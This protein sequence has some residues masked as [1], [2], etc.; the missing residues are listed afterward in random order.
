MDIETMPHA[1]YF[2]G[3][4]DTVTKI[5]QV[6]YQT[7]EY[8]E[9]GMFTAKLMIDTPIEIFID[10]G[11]TPSI[12]PLHT[13]NKFP[14]LCTYPKTESNIP[15]HTG[16]GLITS[17]FWLEI[18]LKLQHQTI[19]IKALVCDSE[20]PYDLILGRISMAQLSAWQDYTTNKLYIQQISIPLTVRN[21]IRILPGKTGIVT[22]T[23]QPNK[24]S[25][26][27]RHTIIG[28]G[29]AYVKLLDQNLPL[30]PI[31]IELKNNHCCM[32]VHNTS[33][34]TVEF[35]HGQEMAYFDARSKGLVQ[36]NNSKHFPIDQYLHDRMTPATL[37]PS[38]LAYEKPI[39]PT[40]IPCI[41]TRTE[42]PIDVTNKSTPDDK[43]PR[44]DPDDPRRNM[45]DKEIL[46][47]KLNLKDSI[48][49]EKEKEEFLM[50]VEQFTDVFSLRDEIGTCP[51]IEVHLKL[52]DKTPFFVRPY[53]MREEQK[54]V[55]QKEM[56]RLEH[57]GII[58]KGLTSYSSLVVLVKWKNQNLYQVCSD[59]CILNEKL[60]KINHTFP[61][62]RNYIGRFGRKK[63]H[64]LSTINLRDAFHTLR[65]ALSSQ[66]YCG[67]TTYYGSPTYHYLHMGMGMSVSPQIWQQF[68]DLVFQD[69]LI[70][71]KQNFDVILDD[72]FIHS[73]AKEHMDDLID[74]FKVLRKY[75]LKL[76]PHK[77][78]FFK[79]KIIYMGLEF[80]IQEDK[81]CYTQLKDKCDAIQN[82]ESPTTLRQTRAF[83]GMVNFLLSFLPNLHRLLIPIYDLQ[84]KAKMFKWTEEAERVFNDIKKL[85][86][87][88]LV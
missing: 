80:Q 77:C 79:K 60:V 14:I 34:S 82:L 70:K 88:P 67:I 76:S 40:K 26:M 20:C 15:I 4:S 27:P 49:N 46:Q 43:Y 17:H 57:L 39:H 6:P 87:N 41:T 29:I 56:D 3:N 74:L 31:E 24:T 2:T 62:V 58:C 11:A 85:L 53:P 8:N 55:I 16:G 47:M 64:Y 25:F 5:N 54:K 50:K 51:F 9:N 66:K 32:E 1:M 52:K 38:P 68:I 75:G 78:Q 35:L 72:T 65:L 73:T 19:Q 71:R 69:D 28:K 84:K 44:L 13:Y 22:L 42:L 23:L 21:N 81:V 10:N 33:D 61:L 37:S 18:P 12:L 48:L 83:C 36:I 59:F 86:I 30:R 45:T 63:C 7:I